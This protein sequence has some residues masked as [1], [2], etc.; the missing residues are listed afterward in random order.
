MKSIFKILSISTFAAILITP[1]VQA[2]IT[3]EP[4]STNTVVNQNG[5]TFTIKGGTQVDK[6]VFHSLQKFGLNEN[7]IADFVTNPGT[8]NVLG[9]ITG[10]DASVING[11]IKVTG[12][13]A[14]LYLM[15]PAGIIFGSGARLDV[16]GS[17][18]ATTANGIGFGDNWFNATGAN[19]YADLL[20]EPSSFAFTMSEP[21]TIFNAG[22]LAVGKGKTLNL[23]GGIVINTG[24]LSSQGGKIAIAAIPDKKLV[25]ISQEGNLLSLGLPTSTANNLNPVNFNPSSLPQLLT[26]GNFNSATGVTV[27]NGIVKLTGSGVE[28]PNDA[29][30]TVVSNKLDAAGEVGGEVNVLGEKVGVVSANINASGKNRGGTVLMGGDYKG[31]GTVPNAQRTFIS[32]D[33]VVKADAEDTGN[34]GKVIAWA[35][36]T[37]SFYGEISARGGK[38]AGD[39]GF[40]EVS[41]KENLAFDGFVDVGADFGKGGELLLDPKTVEIVSS[42]DDDNELDDQEILKN[43]SLGSTF[44]ISADKVEDALETGD[45]KIEATNNIDVKSSI[46]PFLNINFTDEN[47]FDLTLD[48]PSININNSIN[49]AGGLNLKAINDL[50]IEDSQL[51]VGEDITLES[52]KRVELTET[53]ADSFIIQAKGNITIAGKEG[54]KITAFSN[55]NSILQSGGDFSLISDNDIIGNARISSGGNF[56]AGPGKFSQSNELNLNGVIS[57]NGDVSFD[58]YTGSSL[59]VE[60]K[61]SIRGG[62]INITDAGTFPQTGGDPDVNILNAVPALILRAGVTELANSSSPAANLGDTSFQS[63]VNPSSQGGIKVKNID[64]DIGTDTD[65]NKT[66][67]SVILSAKGDIVTG[68]IKARGP[69]GSDII[70]VADS[71]NIVSSTGKVIVDHIQV[72]SNDNAFL[73][74]VNIDSFGV[75]QARGSENLITGTSFGGSTNLSNFKA[76]IAAP[77]KISIKHGG[78]SFKAALGLEK[79]SNGKL[80]FRVLGGPNDERQVVVVGRDQGG[81]TVQGGSTANLVFADNGASTTTADIPGLTIRNATFDLDNLSENTSYTVGGMF[82]QASTDA[83]L[84]GSFRDTELSNSSDISVV[85]IPK[86]NIKS[87]GGSSGNGTSNGQQSSDSSSGKKTL[88]GQPSLN[89]QVVQNQLNQ[90]Q[91][92]DVC[93]PKSST[94]ALN[95]GENTSKES[96]T[97]NSQSSTSNPCGTADN[98]KKNNILTVIPDRRLDSDSALPTSLLRLGEK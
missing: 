48:A 29:G 82:I 20:G 26:G 63:T 97:N 7:Q 47:T 17:F 23:L 32:Q 44:K 92:N 31:E 57:S 95:R 4:N 72:S 93:P 86:P 67:S 11:L 85:A 76:S 45:V 5:D 8:K 90:E 15:N 54:I 50:K 91:K 62:N 16:P 89:E 2:Q 61:G 34:G 71:V 21:G 56:S 79:D 73:G 69:S 68:S 53:G 10:G 74:D 80:I 6:N 33:S 14:N 3:V 35:D 59:K 84:Y 40:V 60:A 41:G 70:I 55:P 58:D 30:T 49:V 96:S 43:E 39:G 27:E 18:T 88:N 52:E 51:K 81:P 36:K 19:N 24:T 46:N 1:K 78:E 66:Q 28:I 77:G 22:N 87:P 83:G 9:R 25:K 42:G 12:S 65:T 38:D 98:N 94:V 37:T 13:N 64:T 75:F